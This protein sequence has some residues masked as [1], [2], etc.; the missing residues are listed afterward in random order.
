MTF[1]MQFKGNSILSTLELMLVIGVNT[2]SEYLVLAFQFPFFS[3]FYSFSLF[4]FYLLMHY[5]I[6]TLVNTNCFL[7]K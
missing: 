3:N 1:G 6:S 5:V 2:C 7:V 4:A